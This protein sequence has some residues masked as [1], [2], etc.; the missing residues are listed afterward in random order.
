[1]GLGVAI[2]RETLA[3]HG[4]YVQSYTRGGR[5]SFVLQCPIC[6]VVYVV[7]CEPGVKEDSARRDFADEISKAHP[8]HGEVIAIGPVA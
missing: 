5:S 4:N 3:L 8:R 6:D 7:Y 2:R 1:M